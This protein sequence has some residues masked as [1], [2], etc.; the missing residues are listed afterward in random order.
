MKLPKVVM[1]IYL[2]FICLGLITLAF[3]DLYKKISRIEAESIVHETIEPPIEGIE[4]LM[5][6]KY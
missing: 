3:M 5:Q 6:P 1:L 2:L 4:L